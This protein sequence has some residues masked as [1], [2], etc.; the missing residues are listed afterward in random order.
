MSRGKGRAESL[1]KNTARLALANRA[2]PFPGGLKPV[3]YV[4]RTS[5]SDLQ[6]IPPMPPGPPAG[7]SFF[8]SGISETMASVVRRSEAIDAAFCSAE[9]TTFVDD[10]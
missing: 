1:Y 7:A 4:V 2:V 9:R 6:Y 8:S 3:G 10:G 5:N